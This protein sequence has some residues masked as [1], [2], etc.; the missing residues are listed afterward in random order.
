V[1][2][3][4]ALLKTMQTRIVQLLGQGESIA[5]KKKN[6]ILKLPTKE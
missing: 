2:I 1:E 5:E 3:E 6:A 4:I